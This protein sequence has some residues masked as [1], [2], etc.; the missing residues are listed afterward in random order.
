[1]ILRVARSVQRIHRYFARS[2]GLQSCNRCRCG[3]LPRRCADYAKQ[4]S[5]QRAKVNA[6]SLVSALSTV[7]R[8]GIDEGVI[9]RQ[10]LPNGSSAMRRAMCTMWHSSIRT[11]LLGATMS[12]DHRVTGMVGEKGDLTL[13][14]PCTRTHARTT[15]PAGLGAFSE[16]LCFLM[17]DQV[18]E[19]P[20][21]QLVPLVRASSVVCRRWL[22]CGWHRKHTDA[23]TR[24]WRRACVCGMRYCARWS[25]PPSSR[26]PA[27]HTPWSMAPRPFG[28]VGCSA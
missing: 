5:R 17:P 15:K 25:P 26:A 21:Y 11:R 14:Y 23:H 3:P 6:I 19:T 24:C 10:L 8:M 1:V 22:V 18:G 27:D 20:V 7:W 28:P 16:C 12:V 9:V 4:R 13:Q 2:S